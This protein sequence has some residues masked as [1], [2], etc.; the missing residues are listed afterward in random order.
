MRNWSPTG[1]VQGSLSGSTIS[2]RTNSFHR[3][4]NANP[5][6]AELKSGPL[7]PDPS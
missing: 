7:G 2:G 1:S 6:G 3:H 5:A 4:T